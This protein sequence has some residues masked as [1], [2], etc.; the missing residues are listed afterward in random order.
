MKT[1]LEYFKKMRETWNKKWVT[2]KSCGDSNGE[3]N[4]E[5]EQE[6]LKLIG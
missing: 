4:S 5:I 2:L 1:L 3:N 6:I